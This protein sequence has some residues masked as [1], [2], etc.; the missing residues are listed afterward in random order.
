MNFI[1]IL[2]SA[3]VLALDLFESHL[4]SAVLGK[5]ILTSVILKYP[6]IKPENNNYSSQCFI[7]IKWFLYKY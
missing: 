3:L 4:Q 1:K 5:S 6:K 7:K 2:E